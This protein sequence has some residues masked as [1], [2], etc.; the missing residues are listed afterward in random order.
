MILL[1]YT[2]KHP[3]PDA[4]SCTEARWRDYDLHLR[5]YHAGRETERKHVHTWK[6]GKERL[7]LVDAGIKVWD[8]GDSDQARTKPK[9]PPHAPNA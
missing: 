3:F 7:V 1:I 8:T 9:G 6:P 2:E 4:I 5:N